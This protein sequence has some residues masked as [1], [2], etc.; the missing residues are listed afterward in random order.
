M[1]VSYDN[2]IISRPAVKIDNDNI[3]IVPDSLKLPP[4]LNPVESVVG[5]YGIEEATFNTS[6][7]Q[8]NPPSTTFDVYA[9]VENW[10]IFNALSAS[11]TNN[12]NVSITINEGGSELI[13][14]N[15]NAAVSYGD[16]NIAS[17]GK[18][19]ITVTG[20]WK[21]ITS[22]FAQITT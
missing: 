8:E 4:S 9:T 17:K 18:V 16:F 6:T 19:T 12:H 21:T 5:I 2:Q 14:T 11:G 10:T 22:S 15:N 7:V 3:I 1:A 13:L 20:K